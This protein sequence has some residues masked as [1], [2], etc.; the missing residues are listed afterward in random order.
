MCILISLVEWE[1]NVL[2]EEHNS[3]WFL[4]LITTSLEMV[5]SLSFLLAPLPLLLNLFWYSFCWNNFFSL[6]NIFQ[7]SLLKNINNNWHNIINI[8][9]LKKIYL[10][11]VDEEYYTYLTE[12]KKKETCSEICIGNITSC[13]KH[14]VHAIFLEMI[15][16][17]RI[18]F[19]VQIV[20]IPKEIKV[21]F[22][23]I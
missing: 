10:N 11:I 17:F 3:F 14:F 6:A 16:Q 13:G 1:Q 12:Q 4:V 8:V 9:P 19:L 15:L 20:R 21:P 22:P 18:E 5:S 7:F 23:P 2:G